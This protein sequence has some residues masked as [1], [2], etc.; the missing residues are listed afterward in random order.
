[1]NRSRGEFKHS[2]EAVKNERPGLLT[3]AKRRARQ[4]M[5]D[6]RRR[7]PEDLGPVFEALAASLFKP[8]FN[9]KSAVPDPVARGRF[10]IEV[11]VSPRAYR[12]RYLLETALETIQRTSL[13]ILEIAAGLG[14]AEPELFRKWFQWRTGEAPLTMRSQAAGSPARAAG[15]PPRSAVA[16][17]DQAWST[18]ECRRAAAW[19]VSR[20][21][22]VV[23]IEE[24][25]ALYPAIADRSTPS[26]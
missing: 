1:M 13:P 15:S 24:I 20:E 17:G 16:N 21:R 2:R 11:G 5:D 6:D 23:L 4:R 18:R 9:A 12:D 19:D 14:F 3:A 10:R 8:D 7:Y 25:R 26:E 22:G